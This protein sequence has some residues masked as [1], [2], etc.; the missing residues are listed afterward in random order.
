MNEPTHDPSTVTLFGETV[1][2]NDDRRMKLLL[3][4]N[5]TQMLRGIPPQVIRSLFHEKFVDFRL[6]TV[7]LGFILQRAA[8]AGHGGIGMETMDA[9]YS[10][11]I[12]LC[13]LEPA[14]AG[15]PPDEGP[16]PAEAA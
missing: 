2:I 12:A 14:A 8:E 7:K 16:A 13:E 11:M 9:F 5:A 3:G 1:N 6:V 10:H 15:P 4:D